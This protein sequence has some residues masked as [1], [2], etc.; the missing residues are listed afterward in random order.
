V[1]VGLEIDGDLSAAGI[2]LNATA[3]IELAHCFHQFVRLSG[4]GKWSRNTEGKW[5]LD[6]LKATAFEVLDDEPLDETLSKLK[7]LLEPGS[8]Q[9][10][11]K[12]VDELRRA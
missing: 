8:A 9:E 10:I 12:N 2:S 4:E 7:N 5:S 1:K 11:V 3:A 6:N